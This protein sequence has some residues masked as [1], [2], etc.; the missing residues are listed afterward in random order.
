M[1]AGV[2][3]IG[4]K[5]SL[6][7]TS[8]MRY[9]GILCTLNREESTIA[10]QNVRSFGTEGRTEG[11]RGQH[12]VPM[13]NEIYDFIVF[14]GK[15]L[16][17]L[18][19][20]QELRESQPTRAPPVYSGPPPRESYLGHSFNKHGIEY[21]TGP[22]MY[23]MRPAGND[24]GLGLSSNAAAYR[25][26][27][28]VSRNGFVP[29]SLGGDMELG[30]YLSSAS[31]PAVEKPSQVRI[32]TPVQRQA[33]HDG[34]PPPG[35]ER[36]RYEERG[37]SREEA[38]G[39]G[40]PRPSEKVQEPS[41][42]GRQ[43]QERNA[44]GYGPQGEGKGAEK[45]RGRG[46]KG[47]Q[48][49]PLYEVLKQH[50]KAEEAIVKLMRSQGSANINSHELRA[51]SE[52]NLPIYHLYLDFTN[53]CSSGQSF[54][55]MSDEQNWDALAKALKKQ[56]EKD[57]G[58]GQNQQKASQQRPN[59]TLGDYF[60]TPDTKPSKKT[61]KVKQAEQSV[62][63][64]T[65]AKATRGGAG[66]GGRGAG[67]KAKECEREPLEEDDMAG[68]QWACPRCTLRNEQMLSECAACGTNKQAAAMW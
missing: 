28:S 9:E 19:V 38:K 66:R 13:S 31:R 56:F 3:Y 53:Y 24:A 22:S 67:T 60:I 40:H 15:D 34:A 6:I 37:P 11:A 32:E 12:E 36:P 30:G 63:T 62:A 41:L 1:S 64:N 33:F 16:K 57:F 50:K 5:I 47:G 29:G 14:R 45:G 43:A 65:N 18:T 61:T 35:Y 26:A 46:G 27:P 21:D 68:S 4:S 2:P 7:T 23:G 52:S 49:Q 20:L 44:Q 17:D 51:M 10:V 59:N 39:A 58:A 8:D 55:Q 42:Q 54:A 25:Q 48:K